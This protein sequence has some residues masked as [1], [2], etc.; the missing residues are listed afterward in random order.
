MKT[1]VFERTIYVHDKQ[2][3]IMRHHGK[4]SM[5]IS[6]GDRNQHDSYPFFSNWRRAMMRREYL[7]DNNM[8]DV[9]VISAWT[10]YLVGV[11]SAEKVASMLGHRACS[12]RRLCTEPP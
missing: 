8:M 6:H 9:V 1:Q 2:F 4:I 12:R 5:I 11:Y 3:M 7:E 10:E